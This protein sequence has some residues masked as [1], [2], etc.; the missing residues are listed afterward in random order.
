MKNKSNN[1]IK[2]LLTEGKK[3]KKVV[4]AMA[5][6]VVFCTVYA[7][8]LPAVTQSNA[9][10]AQQGEC[11]AWAEIADSEVTVQEEAESSEGTPALMS[12][13]AG[14]GEVLPRDMTGMIT[15]VQMQYK[16]D[17]NGEFIDIGTGGTVHDGDPVRC[18]IDYIV[19]GNT[20]GTG[21]NEISYQL[22]KEMNPEAV[23]SGNVYNSS[24]QQVGTYRIDTDGGLHIF[25]N[26]DYVANN[27]N[28]QDINGSIWIN[29]SASLEHTGN[30][31]TMD[32]PFNDNN[33]IHIQV[34]PV[35]EIKGDVNV[36]KRMKQA[37]GKI[38]NT[39]EVTSKEGTSSE[40]ILKDTMT[41]LVYDSGLIVKDRQGNPIEINKPESGEN[42]FT[43]HLPQMKPGEK[44]IITYY[45]RGDKQNSS[46]HV[47]NGVTAD[48]TNTAGEP[49][50]SSAEAKSQIKVVKKTGT[51][52]KE[53]HTITWK[54]V[55]NSARLNLEGWTLYDYM[56]GKETI[57]AWKNVK[58]TGTTSGKTENIDIPYTFPAGSDDEYTLLIETDA[59]YYQN[60]ENLYENIV[61][62]KDRDGN[63]DSSYAG[64]GIGEYKMI[65]KRGGTPEIVN[66]HV[67]VPWEINLDFVSQNPS[68][69][70]GDT[71]IIKEN[72]SD[73]NDFSKPDNFYQN[74]GGHYFT[75][76]QLAD[77]RRSFENNGILTADSDWVL[78]TLT[79]SEVL[80]NDASADRFKG[81]AV[82]VKSSDVAGKKIRLQYKSTGDLKTASLLKHFGNVISIGNFK[83]KDVVTVQPDDVILEKS[84]PSSPGQAESQHEFSSIKNNE[85][86]WNFNFYIP[87]DLKDRDFT[88]VEKLPENTTLSYLHMKPGR[89]YDRDCMIYWF[90]N[91]DVATIPWW[92]EEQPDKKVYVKI[93]KQKDNS[94]KFQ[95][96]AGLR[97]VAGDDFYHF[98]IK[99]KFDPDRLHWENA[100]E[101]S[102][103]SFKNTVI[104]TG[105]DGEV[106]ASQTQ[107]LIKDKMDGVLSKTGHQN[108]D[109][110]IVPYSVVINPTGINI[111]EKSDTV[112]VTDM[113]TYESDK[114]EFSANLVPN[115]VK[116]YKR[117]S[118]GSK[119]EMLKIPYTYEASSADNKHSH[120]IRAE[121]PD[122]QSLILEYQY[123][124]SG[125]L[126]YDA[127]VR[128]LIKLE[129]VEHAEG[130]EILDTNIHINDSGATANI[131]G[132]ALYKVD[133][134]DHGIFLKGAEFELYG[135]NPS[136]SSYE[137]VKDNNGNTRF[138]T[139]NAGEIVF[140][141]DLIPALTYN[142]AYRLVETRPPE[143]YYQ[144]NKVYDFYI[145][146]KDEESYPVHL[147]DN[148]TGTKLASGDTVY[149]GNT[150]MNRSVT[151]IKKW[152]DEKGEPLSNPDIKS[153][154]VRLYQQLEDGS[155]R[156]LYGTYTIDSEH[157]WKLT[158]DGLPAWEIS[159][160]G[161][162]G[163]NYIY[164]VE[165]IQ[166]PGYRSEVAD[167]NSSEITITNNKIPG[168]VLPETGGMGNAP[169]IIAGILLMTASAVILLRKRKQQNH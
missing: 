15:H 48:S 59:S 67:L 51:Y 155:G 24:S 65:S 123:N 75:K 160:D 100:G 85:L 120:C 135:W 150:S 122:N 74:D 31:Q 121:I 70:L 147:P 71:F 149:Y 61:E 66:D 124:F 111:L 37:D 96:P 126:H 103:T 127:K 146:H 144:G 82:K 108:T 49:V 134:D 10:P 77:V 88:L 104:S 97:D 21:N 68:K 4:S 25:F 142:T 117:N 36:T 5:C 34:E 109:S 69:V 64:V 133:S 89:S 57:T 28:G 118:D 98:S 16:P 132:F 80:W 145:G 9:N 55:I 138:I 78:T 106:T 116:F 164:T 17:S 153:V 33:E 54:I 38:E 27:A 166:V 159:S 152:M 140:S 137:P 169:F 99:V 39:I 29:G 46:I 143:G 43:L 35:V 136:S 94:L 22:P 11:M 157:G 6:V 83:D 40:V 131:E 167:M 2:G 129:G 130:S 44:Y 56:T 91:S 52:N 165:E 93:T 19:P 8:I 50:S 12:L 163:K 161:N 41:G 62:I 90:N 63:P 92:S 119:G 102:I 79:G 115:S 30:D 7:L 158:I 76:A 148:F 60:G 114:T 84:D 18:R 58:M 81:F 23:E 112:F 87:P 42:P 3:W 72:L 20:L 47:K 168:Y 53:S 1:K 14:N 86:S 107:T 101:N 110:N 154:E 73:Q 139:G 151:L 128:N 45:A 162:R 125:K 26:D 13:S 141:R 113:L 95:L 32:L 105:R 156:K